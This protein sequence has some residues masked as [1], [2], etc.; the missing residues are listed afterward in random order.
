MFNKDWFKHPINNEPLNLYASIP[1][2]TSHT[3]VRDASVLWQNSAETWVEN[4]ATSKDERMM[5]FMS[6]SGQIDFFL[7]GSSRSPKQMLKKLADLTG[8]A[9]LPP[10]Y[11]LGFHFSKWTPLSA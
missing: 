10:L 11:S 3:T 8:Y 1:Y 7:F 2:V 5:N 6:V 4:L 9:P